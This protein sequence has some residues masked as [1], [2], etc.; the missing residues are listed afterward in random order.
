MRKSLSH[1]F[2][3][4]LL[5]LGSG[6]GQL[7]SSE[8]QIIVQ[9]R[10]LVSVNGKNITVVDVMK[11]MDVF[12]ARNYPE[13]ANSPTQRHQYYASNWRPMLN[14]MIENILIIADAEKLELKISDAEVR[15]KI[16][17]RFGPNVMASLDEVGITLDEAWDMIYS[18]M[19]VQRMT[20]HR[21]YSKA[22]QRIGPQAIK[23]AYKEF[24]VKN[25]PQDEWKYQVLSIRASTEKIGSVYAQKAYALIRNEPLSFET[26]AKQLTE[27]KDRDSSLKIKVSEEYNV[28]SSSLSSAV[29]TI[30]TSL[31][32]NTYSEPIAQVSRRDKSTVHRI[33]YLKDH[34]IH[35]PPRFNSKVDGLHDDLV[36]KEIELEL[37]LYISKLRQK[38][39]FDES[40]LDELPGNFQPFS[41]K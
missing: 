16:H 24:L 40:Q 6:P 11:K 30:L 34:V 12:L 35:A 39:N 22:M 15:E 10:V 5:L 29:K 23:S 38:F 26:L 18:E 8:Q 27:E 36:Q 2:L 37:P 4:L 41:L 32:P 1:F 20:W 7:E 31:S 14:Q 3:L 28:E 25:P 9:N 19:A 13:M 17:N 33:Y 21:V